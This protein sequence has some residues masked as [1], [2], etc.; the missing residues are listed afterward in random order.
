MKRLLLAACV[1][2]SGCG[3]QANAGPVEESVE[4]LIAQIPRTPTPPRTPAPQ[5]PP[6]SST[7]APAPPDPTP[8]PFRGC[9]GSN[10]EIG[11]C[12]AATEYGWTGQQWVDLE[13][14][15]TK[16][17]GWRTNAKNGSCWGIPQSCPGKKMASAGGDWRTNP[18]TQIRWGL[19]Y[20]KGRYKT[21]SNAWAHF[22]RHNYY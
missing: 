17:S 19:R 10:R 18:H 6:P 12:Q 5:P 8:T 16:E 14:L 20:I 3:M 11:Q 9:S 2:M 15:W 4:E 1:L 13:R 7:P 21:P 22:R